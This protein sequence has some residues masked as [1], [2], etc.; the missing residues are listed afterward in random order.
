MKIIFI[1]FVLCIFCYGLGAVN[2]KQFYDR[3]YKCTAKDIK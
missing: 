3:E 2:T 1:A